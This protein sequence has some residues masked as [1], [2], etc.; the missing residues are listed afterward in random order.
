M[1]SLWNLFN[2]FFGDEVE[3]NDLMWEAKPTKGKI[4][5]KLKTKKFKMLQKLSS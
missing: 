4:R 1:K 3:K 2:F 5:N